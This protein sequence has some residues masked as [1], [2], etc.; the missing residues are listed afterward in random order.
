MGR[1]AT[2]KEHAETKSTESSGSKSGNKK[3]NV[4]FKKK[5]QVHTVN[6]QFDDS[7]SSGK[8]MS[9]NVNTLRVVS[10]DEGSDGF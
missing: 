3:D 2:W 9:A 1:R 8:E 4:K 6:T 7:D 10:V 5:R